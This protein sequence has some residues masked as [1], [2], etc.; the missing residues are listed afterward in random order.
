MGFVFTR[1]AD[2]LPAA[3]IFVIVNG[4][5]STGRVTNIVPKETGK[6]SFDEYNGILGDF[7]EQGLRVLAGVTVS[8]TR[9]DRPITDWLSETAA[10]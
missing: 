1:V 4:N 6:L 9:P 5:G 8:E 3:S 2:K 7:L 10:K